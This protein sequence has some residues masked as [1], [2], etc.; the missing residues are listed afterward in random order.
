MIELKPNDS[1]YFRTIVRETST[2]ILIMKSELGG[3][4]GLIKHQWF[5]T[6][7]KMMQASA[8]VIIRQRL[9]IHSLTKHLKAIKLI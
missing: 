1:R 8:S 6:E 5:K 2:F 7:M 9:G 3:N 4:I